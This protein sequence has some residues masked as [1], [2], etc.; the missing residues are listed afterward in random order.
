MAPRGRKA[1]TE[2]A[3]VD[4]T[5]Y[6]EKEPTDLQERFGEWITDKLELE[7]GTKKEQ[8][9]FL[10][11]V[12]LATA[13]R[14]HFQASPEN[15]EVIAERKAARAEEVEEKPK[16]AAKRGRKPKPVPEPEDIEEDVD[17][18]EDVDEV[19]ESEEVEEKPKPVRRTTRGRAATS[20]T[21]GATSKTARRKPA[22][23]SDAPF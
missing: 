12:R 4:Y 23:K 13:L 17:E 18:A 19:E 2:A 16:P 5:V 10:N 1:E 20:K 9:A 3:E 22:A 6:N 14:M 8:A 21:A 11:G 7:F 15:Q